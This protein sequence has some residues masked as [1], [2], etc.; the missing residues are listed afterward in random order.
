MNNSFSDIERSAVYKAIMLRR[1]VRRQ[2][3]SRPIP[4]DVLVRILSAAHHAGSVGFMQ[5]WDFILI[6]DRA[7][8][9]KVLDSFV[10]E[11]DR[12]ANFYEGARRELYLSLKLEGIMESGLNI[13]VTCDRSRGGPYVLG[14]GSIIE[15]D[16][17][18]TCC[19]VQ[20]LWLA[21]RAEGI[22]IGWVS[23]VEPQQLAAILA[24]PDQVIPVAYLCAGYVQDFPDG[25]EL[26]RAGWRN[27]IPLSDL[28]HLDSW[29]KR[30]G[31][32]WGDDGEA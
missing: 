28:V 26:Q 9:Q 10:R 24:L 7:T 4:H 13:C 15:T 5:P 29:N 12:S 20:N 14:R 23:I 6:E 19:A 32:A 22:G 11:R 2:F 30:A 27:R 3:E 17:Y 21:A 1:D 16:V 8:R 25:P 18:S 31:D